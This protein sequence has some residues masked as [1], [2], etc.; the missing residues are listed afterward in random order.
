[1]TSNRADDEGGHVQAKPEREVQRDVPQLS[2]EVVVAVLFDARLFR[3][4]GSLGRRLLDVVMMMMMIVEVIDNIG[5]VPLGVMIVVMMM[6][7]IA[8]VRHLRRPVH[9][10]TAGH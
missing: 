7:M 9:H 1:M 3:L 5:A 6:I 8:V 10:R 2:A 4:L